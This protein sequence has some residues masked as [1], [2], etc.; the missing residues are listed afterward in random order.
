MRKI[1]A[2]GLM[3]PSARPPTLRAVNAR[4][5]YDANI[6]N[7]LRASALVFAD[8]TY[9]L[10]TLRDIAEC[11]KITIPRIYYYL[12]NKEELLYL[13][14]RQTHEDL[15][16]G[17]EKRSRGMERGEDRL[18]VFINN[19]LEYRSAHPAEVKVLIRE[20]ETLTGEYHDEIEQ[21]KREY[22]GSL[23]KILADI[24]AERDRSIDAQD[25]R[26]STILLLNG[27]TGAH[28]QQNP[29]RAPDQ[30]ERMANVMFRMAIG[31]LDVS[32]PRDR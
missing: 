23:R 15:L 6:N 20:A 25:V 7:I 3:K 27:L 22:R 10:A 14:S 21:L 8:K 28:P 1:I 30:Q 17:F 26:L 16:G 9:G 24:A 29:A 2:A 31:A 19:H 13:I 18:R 4:K 11:A 5:A 32:S 12:R